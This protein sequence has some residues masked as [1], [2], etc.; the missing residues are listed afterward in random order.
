MA[1]KF[2]FVGFEGAQVKNRL[3]DFEENLKKTTYPIEWDDIYELITQKEHIMIIDVQKGS[4]EFKKVKNNFEETMP[5]NSIV[6][7]KRI[8]NRR[9]WRT[10]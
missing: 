5:I 3:Q 10:Y 7:V 6:S 4:D 8:Q 1:H 9:L 2:A